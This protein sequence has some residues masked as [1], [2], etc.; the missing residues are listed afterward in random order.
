MTLFTENIS[1]V[2]ELWDCERLRLYKATNNVKQHIWQHFPYRRSLAAVQLLEEMKKRT[3]WLHSV[4]HRSPWKLEHHANFRPFFKNTVVSKNNIGNLMD[5]MPKKDCSLNL[6]KTWFRTSHYRTEHWSLLFFNLTW[7][8]SSLYKNTPFS[9]LHSKEN[10]QQF[11]TVAVDARRQHDENPN[12]NVVTE[13][14]KRL[15]KTPPAAGLWT[16][17]DTL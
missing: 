7:M 3:F 16:S 11:C 5:I 14:M 2:I 1:T 10:F 4:R 15:A 8:K 17:A 13:T 12:S 9:W 6:R